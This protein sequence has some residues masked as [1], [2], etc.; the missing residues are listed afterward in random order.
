[1]ETLKTLYQRYREIIN[2]LFFGVLTTVVNYV[3][4]LVMSPFFVL[5][6]VPT[7]VAWVLSVLFAYL[8]NRK[9]VFCSHST[10]RDAL[11]EAGGFVTARVM[12]G[13]LDVAIMW[14]FADCIGFNDLVIKLLS[15][16]VVV[17]F[18]YV[19]SKLVVFG[20]KKSR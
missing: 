8:T 16:V 19:A 9:Y 15:N 20:K 4:Y 1:M 13:V 5:T 12:S 18:N 6:T 14:V 7:V 11:K 17:V 10:G 3:T 2:Y